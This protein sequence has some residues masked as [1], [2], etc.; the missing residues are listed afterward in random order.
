MPEPEM[1]PIRPTDDEARA[2]AR[3]LIDGARF[4][5]LAVL[6]PGTGF[7]AVTRVGI[8]MDADGNPVTLIS[9]LA[10]HTRALSA[11]PRASLLVGEPGTKGDP[12]THPRLSLTVRADFVPRGGPDHAGLREAWLRDHPKAK[13][14]VDFPDFSFVRFDMLGGALNGGFGRA[15][16]LTPDDLRR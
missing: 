8:G 1:N 5:A 6:A 13:L 15:F 12:L 7:P 9:T 14:Y 3:G 2:L 4:A 11:D 16:D 10:A